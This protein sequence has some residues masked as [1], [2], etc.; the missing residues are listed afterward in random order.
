VAVQTIASIASYLP[1]ARLGDRFGRKP[2]VIATFVAFA[3]FPVTVV[4]AGDFT[5]LLLAFV[6]GGLRELGEPARKALI[7]DLAVP[8]VRARS[9][10]LYYLVR[11]VAITPAA[12]VGGL[13]WQV[14][15]ALPFWVAGAVGLAGVAVFA[16]T[17]EE[18]YAG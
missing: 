10:G 6:V 9:V 13:L 14:S 15:P 4:L 17:G 12:F 11:S 5:T 8:A 18:K 3:A 7:L 2:F 1:A 16:L